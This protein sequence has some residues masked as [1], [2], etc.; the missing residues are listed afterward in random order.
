MKFVIFIEYIFTRRL[1]KKEKTVIRLKLNN[2]VADPVEIWQN[3]KFNKELLNKVI[4]I[5][6]QNQPYFG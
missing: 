2:E 5:T 1:K 4:I 6:L 3:E